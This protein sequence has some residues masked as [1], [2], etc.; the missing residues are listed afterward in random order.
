MQPKKIYHAHSA[1]KCLKVLDPFL[2]EIKTGENWFFS[3]I[4]SWYERNYLTVSINRDNIK[5]PDKLPVVDFIPLGAT[6]LKN[7]MNSL[8]HQL[9]KLCE[10]F[11][12]QKYTGVSEFRTGTKSNV[13]LI[14]SQ[15]EKWK[16]FEVFVSRQVKFA[17]WLAL[18][19]LLLLT[20]CFCA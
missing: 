13:S 18:I 7:L 12:S 8:C 4:A 19:I 16:N 10:F 1:W 2:S 15:L 5:I 20:G 9:H 3:Q 17:S 6:E 11:V 14:L